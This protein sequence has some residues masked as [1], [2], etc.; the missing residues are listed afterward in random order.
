MVTQRKQ[1]YDYSLPT[2]LFE[3]IKSSFPKGTL[4]SENDRTRA[5]HFFHTLTTKSQYLNGTPDGY[6]EL[7]TS[8]LRKMFSSNY[9]R[10][11]G[12]LR[13]NGLIE[14]YASDY[15]KDSYRTSKKT[16]ADTKIKSK[17][18]GQAK[19]FRICQKYSFSFS[20][21]EY[22]KTNNNSKFSSNLS[23]SFKLLPSFSK[24]PLSVVSYDHK[25]KS[26]KES[27]IQFANDFRDMVAKL[28]IDYEKLYEKAYDLV[29]QTNVDQYLVSVYED[30]DKVVPVK[31]V[32]WDSK[33]PMS[34]E[35]AM[36]LAAHRCER[37]YKVKGNYY[38]AG[39]EQFSQRLKQNRLSS[40]TSSIGRL[41]AGDISIQRN[42]TNKRADSNFTNMKS[43]IFKEIMRQ[44]NLFGYD[45]KNS[46]FCIFAN[47]LKNTQSLNTED[48]NL[49]YELATGGSLYEAIADK[50]NITRQ[51][52]KEL[53]FSILFNKIGA[54]IKHK[55]QLEKLFPTVIEYVNNYKKS[56][57]YE[58]FSIFLQNLESEMFM[59]NIYPML[60]EQMDLVFT[61]HDSIVVREENA[62]LTQHIIG[63][64]FEKINFKGVMVWE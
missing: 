26:K 14:G 5:F 50:I 31:V 36:R 42:D 21:K 64:Y 11:I 41:Q 33:V 48:F 12:K 61:K 23:N 39:R 27:D 18:I 54:R 47:Y 24:S 38:M 25:A 7:S 46:Q 56:Y 20:F 22:I 63:Q 58:N 51:G 57:G 43:D 4:R 2:N 16:N 17:R 30:M 49:F 45:L 44:N 32:S 29:N 34:I 9:S 13:S 19:K 35:S 3:A 53:M 1:T 52:A 15:S 8:Y 60:M 59:D 37:L 10:V 6:V 40:Y 62:Q 28:S 55:D